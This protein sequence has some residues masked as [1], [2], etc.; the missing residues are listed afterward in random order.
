MQKRF[1]HVAVLY[2]GTSSEREVSLRSGAAVARGLR[3]SGYTVSEID[4]REPSFAIPDAVEAVFIALH[5][6]FGE[7]GTVQSILES[8][9]LP[10]TGPGV[11]ASRLAFDKVLTKRRLEQNGLPTP[12]WE[13]LP[14]GAVPSISVPAVVKPPR[15][16]SSVGVTRVQHPDQ[17]AQALRTVHDMGQDALVESFIPGRELTVGIV[18][19]QIL[20][21]VEIRAPDGSYD[22]RAKYTA[23][24]TEYLVPAP[25]EPEQTRRCQEL[26]W[27][28]FR[29]LGARGMGRVDLRLTPE[30]D[31]FVLELNT[32]PGFTETSLLPKAAAQVGLDFPALCERILNLA[33]RDHGL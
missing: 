17:W 20:P 22:Y 1:R 27:G 14:R 10:Y 30:G 15:E 8:R 19:E 29:A 5:G 11:E 26:S 18:G 13:I 16:G 28:V 9:G 25:L 7:D 24:V 21:V 23:G 4:V 12:R 3:T 32:I 31:A 33:A 2:G 6:T